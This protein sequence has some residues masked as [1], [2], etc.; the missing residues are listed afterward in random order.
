M[1]NMNQYENYYIYDDPIPYISENTKKHNESIINE[2]NKLNSILKL[3][4]EQKLLLSKLEKE[5]N[6]YTLLINPV[7]MKDYLR[8][9]VSVNCI[10]I[11][12]N[13]IP[14]PNIISM[15]YL[16]FL[17]HLINDDVNG[18]YYKIMLCDLFNLCCGLEISNI[19]YQ[20]NEMNKFNLILGIKQEDGTIR[21]ETINKRDFDNI[22]NI[23]LRQNIPDYNDT[24]ID[25]KVEEALKETEDFINKHKKKMGSLEDQIICVLI[26]TSL[27]LKEIQNLSIRK[28]TKI[29]QRVDYKLHYEIYKT[30]S[31]SGMVS[32]KEEIDHW[33]SEISNKKYS[34]ATDTTVEYNELKNKINSI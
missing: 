2:I 6:N 19:K 34:N 3:D 26:S 29:L 14:N 21:N 30:A 18:E 13:K 8:F 20:A 4:E 7:T 31:M 25:P 9:F 27:N 24:Y 28:F 32:F 5:Y 22:R 12:K 23:I 15:G 10:S 17:F 1:D 33:M 16:D 11:D